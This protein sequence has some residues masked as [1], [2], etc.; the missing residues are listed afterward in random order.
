MYYSDYNRPQGDWDSNSW[1]SEPTPPPKPPKR[2]SGGLKTAALCL[3]CAIAGGI[4]LVMHL[5][6]LRRAITGEDPIRMRD[7]L[8]KIFGKKK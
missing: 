2:R 1:F 7:G 6:N 5:Y 4:I 3:V 8:H